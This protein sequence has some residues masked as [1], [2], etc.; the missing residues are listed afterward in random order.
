VTSYPQFFL[1]KNNEKPNKYDGASFSY[2]DL[3]DF[4]NVYSE[5]FVF[6]G[7]EE[8]VESAATKPWLNEKLPHLTKDSGNDICFKKDGT[9]CVIYVHTGKSDAIKEA[10][11]NNVND[12]F[13][14]AVTRGIRFSFMKLDMSREAQ[15]AA[16][17][18]I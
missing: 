2:Q 5:T 8:A 16:A 6:G 10:T 12:N 18:G 4:I 15:F 14:K 1:L 13:A 9:L 11:L 3:F 7:D 17:F